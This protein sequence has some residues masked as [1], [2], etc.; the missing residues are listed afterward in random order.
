[1]KIFPKTS[2]KR[3]ILYNFAKEYFGVKLPKMFVHSKNK[4]IYC[5]KIQIYKSMVILKNAFQVLEVYIR[6]P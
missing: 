4:R 1:M 3:V 6:G 2:R 5:S